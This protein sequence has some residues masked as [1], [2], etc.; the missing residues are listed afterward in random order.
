MKTIAAMNVARTLVSVTPPYA[1][2]VRSVTRSSYSGISSGSKLTSVSVAKRGVMTPTVFKR[3]TKSTT[4][5]W[6]TRPASL[7]FFISHTHTYPASAGSPAWIEFGR[8]G[9]FGTTPESVEIAQFDRWASASWLAT[10]YADGT[11][12]S[13]SEQYKFQ[14]RGS[15]ATTPVQRKA[16]TVLTKRQNNGV[17]QFGWT[18]GVGE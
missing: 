3:R 5:R 11:A 7:L 16:L 9:G 10:P 2:P 6:E 18:L 12:E 13:T 17:Q 1:T 15:G 8:R 14:Q 4:N